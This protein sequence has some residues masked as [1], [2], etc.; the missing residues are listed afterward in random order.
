MDAVATAEAPDLD[1]LALGGPIEDLL[2]R[3]DGDLRQIADGE[4]ATYIPELA[5]ADPDRFAVSLSTIDGSRYSAGD[6]ELEFTIQ[7]VSKPFVY[8]LALADRG[9]DDVLS[10]VGVEP[11]GD[12]F[13]SITID[14][15]TG[16]PFNP[17]VNAGAI[18]TASLVAGGN[19][20]EQF[21]RI[22][23]GLSVFA[24]RELGVD[25][26]VYASERTTGDRNRAIAYLM[27][28][29]GALDS[30]VD[31]V[32]DVYFRQ[33]AI[34]VTAPD[35][36]MMAATLANGGV[37][38]VTGA[39][40]MRREHVERVLTVMATC[41]MY[42]YAGEWLFRVGLPAKSGVSG[43]IVAVLPGQLG[44][45]LYGPRL[46]ERG[47]SVRGIAACERLSDRLGLHVL[48][49]KGAPP[50]VVRRTYRADVVRSKRAR[51][52]NEVDVLDK[53][54]VSVIVYE[55]QG[56]QGFASTEALI[57]TIRANLD[58]VTSVVLDV[59]RVSA[60][61]DA[62]LV[63]LGGLVTLLADRGVE[64][65]IAD[66]RGLPG[67][68]R[69]HEGTRHVRRF[70]DVESALEWCENGLLA[71]A[72]VAQQELAD[73]RVPLAEQELATGMSPAALEILESALTTRVLTEG[74]VIFNEGDA[75]DSLYLVAAGQVSVDIRVGGNGRRSRLTSIGPGRAFGEIALID[76]GRRSSRVV[77]D[78]PTLCYELT[79]EALD[80]LRRTHPEVAAEL[81]RAIAR[82][83]SVTLR[84][85][86][87]EIRS[88]EH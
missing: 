21:E 27:R 26:R 54:G 20:A 38:P 50:S 11:T 17:M 35:L 18:L 33:C 43:G 59:R 16:R 56:D 63:L 70:L 25:E 31:G 80:E 9:L 24:G 83:L 62:A 14:E 72:G 79:R 3:L 81:Y 48:R 23:D 57:R 52:Q 6:A 49:P 12:P 34:R 73:R 37:N 40:A 86:T 22:R 65:V 7:S 28:T 53:A 61:D 13:N 29:V 8:A 58:G 74:V 39:A 5:T 10:R 45:G 68:A 85:A 42:D 32:L 87:S 19:R 71:G 77:V 4:L 2:R 66:P 15:R 82:S 75:A 41:G 84:R 55:V 30:D 44:I 36:S 60:V 64:F 76:G 46:D 51:P 47:N 88:L 1:E 78:Q 67:V 69:T